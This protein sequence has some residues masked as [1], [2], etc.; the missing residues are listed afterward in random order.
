MRRAPAT[1]SSPSAP[2]PTT[3]TRVWAPVFAR[4][5]ACHDTAAGSTR[6]RVA[7]VESR[8]QHHDAFGRRAELLRHAAVHGDPERGSRVRRAAVVPTGSA[9]LTIATAV[10]RLHNDACSVL[11]HARDLVAEDLAEPKGDVEQVRA[12]DARRG[13]LKQLAIGH[14]RSLVD[15]DDLDGIFC[16]P[17]TAFIGTAAPLSP[18]RRVVPGGYPRARRTCCLETCFDMPRSCIPVHRRDAYHVVVVEAMGLALVDR[19][20]GAGLQDEISC[21]DAD[22]CRHERPPVLLVRCDRARNVD[23]HGMRAR[24]VRCGTNRCTGDVGE[25]GLFPP[26]NGLFH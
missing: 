19:E 2:A 18:A 22:R 25:R 6:R 5:S 16:I 26:R 3:A 10:H 15:V 24:A 9:L 11:A 14:P 17:R 4:L 12:A 8:R 21:V 7:D 13:D 23:C 1:A 20:E